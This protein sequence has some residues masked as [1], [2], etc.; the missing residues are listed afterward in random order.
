MVDSVLVDS[1]A[2]RLPSRSS[3][4]LVISFSSRVTA[5]PIWLVVNQ[6]CKQ[7]CNRFCSYKPQQFIFVLRA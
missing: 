7:L 3:L 4:S 1:L 2:T 5:H 6:R